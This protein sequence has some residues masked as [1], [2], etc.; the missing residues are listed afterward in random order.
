MSP[1]NPEL[2][3]FIMQALND[4]ALVTLCADHFPEVYQ[5]FSDGL[6]KNRKVLP[7]IVYSDSRS[8]HPYRRG[9]KLSQ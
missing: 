9:R 1:T 7:L 5:N 3:Q 8:L 6:T 2:C 4:E